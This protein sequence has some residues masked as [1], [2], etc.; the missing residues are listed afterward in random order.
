LERNSWIAYKE[1]GGRRDF[2]QF[3]ETCVRHL[4]LDTGEGRLRV[5][6]NRVPTNADSAHLPSR[7][8]PRPSQRR[9]AKRCRICYEQQGDTIASDQFSAVRAAR[10][11]QVCA[12]SRVLLCGISAMRSC[13]AYGRFWV[14]ECVR[15][16]CCCFVSS[17]FCTLE[18][19]T[20]C[21]CVQLTSL[22]ST[23]K[24]PPKE[25]LAANLFSQRNFTEE[26]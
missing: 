3:I 14:C 12:W 10:V 24:N 2:L 21:P 25:W 19:A 23:S 18:P 1:L 20:A 16:F 15:L 26:N 6:Q 8:P 22:L 13:S 11:T 5:I 4:L 7:L 9:P 17:P